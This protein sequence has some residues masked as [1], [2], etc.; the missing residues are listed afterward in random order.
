MRHCITL[1]MWWEIDIVI[2]QDRK[3]L[4]QHTQACWADHV[5]MYMYIYIATCTCT[6][7]HCTFI[8]STESKFRHSAVGHYFIL[9]FVLY[10]VYPAIVVSQTLHEMS[11]LTIICATQC[12]NFVVLLLLCVLVSQHSGTPFPRDILHRSAPPSIRVSIA[13]CTFVLQMI[14]KMKART[15]TASA[16]VIL[17]T[18]VGIVTSNHCSNSGSIFMCDL[19]NNMNTWWKACVQNLT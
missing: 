11:P 10:Y 18:L 7:T 8:W 12:N 16:S 15:A 6:C 1:D 14:L 13:A 19:S 9:C 3:T 5:Y 4:D 17:L 2:H